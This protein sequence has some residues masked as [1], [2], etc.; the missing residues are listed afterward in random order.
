MDIDP[1]KEHMS[2]Q[3]LVRHGLPPHVTINC[4]GIHVPAGVGVHGCGVSTPNAAAV[5]AAT[6][7]FASEVHIP[8]GCIFT[9]GAVSA[10]VAT[11][12]PS[13]KTVC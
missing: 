12:L 10:I 6:A 7:G 8:K 11:G 13:T 1:A 5:A 9:I 3:S 4:E 2:L